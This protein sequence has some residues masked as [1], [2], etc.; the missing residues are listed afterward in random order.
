MDPDWI[1]FM[2]CIEYSRGNEVLLP[3]KLCMHVFGDAEVAGL[4][5]EWKL[6][7]HVFVCCAAGPLPSVLAGKQ[8]QNQRRNVC[9]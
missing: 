9:V 7:Y 8:V 4:I 2:Q 3:P 6:C 1:A 5:S